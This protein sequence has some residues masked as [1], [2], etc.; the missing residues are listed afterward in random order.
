MNIILLGYGKMGKVIE[1]VALGRGHT[2]SHKIDLNNL[3]ELAQIDP[4]GVDA[5]IEFSSPESAVSNL[6]YCFEHHIPVV[7]GTTG[8]LYRKQEMEL[9]CMQKSGAFFYASNYSLGVNIFFH[10]N[11]VL[12]KL[13][14]RYSDYEVS[15]EEIHH[16][17]KKDAPSGTALSLAKDIIDS[18]DRK[19]GW[20]NEHATEP[21]LL[22]IISL[23]EAG[24]PGTHTVRYQSKEDTIEI[25]HTAH[26]REGFAL[27]A[28]VAAEW[29]Q[30]KQGVFN[31][32]DMMTF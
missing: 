7:C 27:G 19:E 26:S 2:I 11:R 4:S 14:N 24:V 13:M 12:S 31:M 15:M 20:V 23:R 1:Q 5:A 28:V 16:T 3:K 30:G 21:S 9:L 18:I 32:Q 22:S 29:I 17:E 25:K 8:W 10:L 6:M